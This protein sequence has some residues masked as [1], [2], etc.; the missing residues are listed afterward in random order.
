MDAAA[1]AALPVAHLAKPDCALLMWA[2]A[3]MLP[4]AIELMRA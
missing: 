4:D 2:T 3:P 1:L